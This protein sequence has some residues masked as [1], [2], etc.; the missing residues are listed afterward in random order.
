MIASKPSG[1]VAGDTAHDFAN[2]LSTIRTHTHLIKR[3]ATPQ[4]SE[5]LQA[6]DNA[7]EFGS[8]L[9]ERLLAFARKQN[10]TP[11]K[12][13]LNGLLAGMIELVEI[14]LKPA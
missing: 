8:S 9:T 7:I 2:I 14:G 11:E 3:M 6:M 5:N 13:E 10:L 4:Q 1:K 12:V